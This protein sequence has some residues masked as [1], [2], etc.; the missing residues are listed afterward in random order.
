MSQLQKK[1]EDFQGE[2]IVRII[3]VG[4][5]KVGETL[6]AELSQEGDDITVIDRKEDK[7]ER[8]CNAYDIMGCTGNGAGYSTQL[9]AG[10]KEADLLIA[11][12]GSDELNLLCCL[13]ARKAGN[14]QTIARVRTPEYSSEL[15]YLKEELGLAMVLNQELATAMELARVLKFPSAI[16]IDTFAKGRVDL[17]RFRIPADSPLDQMTLNE[18]HSRLKSNVL[19]C[20][21]EHGGEI[22]IPTGDSRME[23]GDVISIVAASREETPFFRKIGLQ[24]NQV[25]NVLIVGGGQ[26]SYYL[27]R[28]LCPAG[29]RVKIIE[30]QMKRCEELCELLPK[31]TIIHGDGTNRQLL[32]EEGI[33]QTEGFVALTDIDEENVILSLYAKKCGCRKVITKVNRLSFDEVID[34]LDLD[35]RVCPRDITAESILQYVRSV[36]NSIGS[37]VETLHRISDNQAEA[38]EFV[39]RDNFRMTEVSLQDLPLKPGI[40]IASINRGGQIILPRGK[41]ES[42]EGDTVIVITTRKGLNDIN[43]I[44]QIK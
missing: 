9:E 2:N 15:R 27:A 3:I 24:T 32:E 42:R 26:I 19:V 35:T 14:C 6:A 30:R 34:S 8:L 25:K 39:I 40:L 37:N 12:T 36:K 29:I 7:V 31:A 10:I 4:C 11:V 43:D 1:N 16:D 5:G 13:L 21:L 38:L 18:M 17:L 22:L 33:E 44:L 28:L 41:D 20:T 23:A